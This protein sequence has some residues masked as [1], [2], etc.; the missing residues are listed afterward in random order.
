MKNIAW[1]LLFVMGSLSL[2]GCGGPMEAEDEYADEATEEMGGALGEALG[3]TK[4]EDADAFAIEDGAA[5][6]VAWCDDV[7]S[8][9]QAWSDYEAQVLTLVNQKR[10][11]GASC[12]GVAYPPAPAL[13]LDERL[14]CAARKHSKDMGVKNFF[15]HTGS[16]GST[17]WQRINSAGYTY[18]TAAEN[19]AAGYASPT[20]VVNGWMTSTGHC[21]NI[22]NAKLKQLGVGYYEGTTGYKKYWTQ[23]FGTP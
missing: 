19:I 1:S 15:S 17:P 4:D 5:D 9:N 18:K 20:A 22:M 7:V 8:W 10:A 14:R 6:L 12:G 23:D 2:I 13:T 11:A 3:T 16:N 21:K